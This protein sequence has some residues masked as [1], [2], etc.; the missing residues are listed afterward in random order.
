MSF[1]PREFLRHIVAETDYLATAG[2]GVTRAQFDA[3]VTL[4]RAFVRSLEIIGEASKRI[5]DDLR[6]ANP[7]V[8]PALMALWSSAL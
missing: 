7:D 5:P 8:D 2:A 6:A 1:E 4:Q 3:D